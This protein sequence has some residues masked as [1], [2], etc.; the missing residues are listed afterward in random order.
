MP[1]LDGQQS[2][3]FKRR[4]SAQA[5]AWQNKAFDLANRV[6]DRANEEGFFGINMASTGHGKTLGN[7]RIMYA[8]AE[9]GKG[10]RFTIAQ[11]LRVLTM[12]TGE[13]LRSRLHLDPTAL[14]VLVGGSHHP[15]SKGVDAEADASLAEKL[16]SESAEAI[17]TEEIYPPDLADIEGLLPTVLNNPKSR[18][19]VGT[20]IVSC[21]IDHLVLATECLRGGR[22]IAP[23]LRLLTSDLVLDELDDFDQWDL[24]AVS[25]LV[26]FA[27]MLGAKV[28][29]SSATLTPGLL[30][31]LFQAYR[32]GRARWQ[33][34]T[35]GADPNRSP[36]IV[37]AWF[38]E[39]KVTAKDC[40]SDQ[41]FIDA[42]HL[43]AVK[44][45][46][47]LL[48]K[49]PRRSAEVIKPELA[50]AKENQKLDW[51][52]L[53][54][55]LLENA[56]KLHQR[57]HDSDA[58]KKVSVGLIRFANI[59]P[60]IQ[61]VLACYSA[62]ELRPDVQ[63]H[64]CCYH[65]QHLLAQRNAIEQCLDKVLQRSGRES[66]FLEPLIHQAI[67]N[68][69]RPHH[70][71]IVA[72]TAVAE[73]GRDHD[74]DWSIID[75]SSMRSI[76][77][78]V[79]RVWRHR[80][81]KTLNE[82][83]VAILNTNVKA[84]TEGENLGVGSTAVFARPGF[85]MKDDFM[86]TSHRICKLIDVEVLSNLNAVPRILRGEPLQPTER[87]ADLE[88]GVMDQF[89][90]T[91]QCNF[92]NAFWYPE[93]ANTLTA[94]VQKLTPFRDQSRKQTEYVCLLENDQP[95]EY[96][97]YQAEHLRKAA[98][99]AV[100]VNDRFKRIDFEQANLS[101]A[102]W[103]NLQLSEALYRLSESYED[104]EPNQLASKFA[105]VSLPEPTGGHSATRWNFNP[106]LGFWQWE[107][108]DAFKL[109]RANRRAR[110][111]ASP[112]YRG[113]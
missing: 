19:L 3:L 69:D 85:E 50:A 48:S 71:F 94:H 72:A 79:G 75:P 29:V 92:V 12:Q 40:S 52:G 39:D 56:F 93:T 89:F 47:R 38:D 65:S 106:F 53:S 58:D 97:F 8:L 67:N 24:P 1:G 20:P 11:G 101:V 98:E 57:Y 100:T 22:H 54:R 107:D 30:A 59:E 55:C 61:T 32:E 4:T 66:L 9:P 49:P 21:T 81:D 41:A 110:N 64:I 42:H 35:A 44:R 103:I 112:N 68:S 62:Q 83:N 102:A 31:G 51:A 105:T 86:L 87:L 7:A 45:A 76:I 90:D 74:Y 23:M 63:F 33:H 43:F 37:C 104:V 6:R 25:R 95:D 96:E 10:V 13:A 78:L 36:N 77:Q 73:V 91:T 16:G 2:S 60:L 28:L 99:K 15:E 109:G 84:M 108:A 46:S 82:P 88:H 17:V 111:S 34:Q 26:H 70:I 5:F 113:D 18:K 27:G 80:P 14:A